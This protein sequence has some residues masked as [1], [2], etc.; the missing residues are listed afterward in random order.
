M[1]YAIADHHAV[2]TSLSAAAGDDA[3]LTVFDYFDSGDYR[4]HAIREGDRPFLLNPIV[5]ADIE[6]C[7]ATAG[8][9]V[10]G[11]DRIGADY[12]RWYEALVARIDA[13]RGDMDIWRD[14]R[15]FAR[16]RSLY[17]GLRDVL[18]QGH[19]AGAVIRAERAA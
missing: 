3:I 5:S 9:Q 15:G 10:T 7:L 12:V 4:D 18:R 14:P 19:L 1:P 11:V 6:P 16:V 13:K 8:W 2:L 17:A